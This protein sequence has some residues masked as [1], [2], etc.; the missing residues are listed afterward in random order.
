MRTPT[1]L[2]PALAALLAA[3]CSDSASSPPDAGPSDSDAALADAAALE[4]AGPEA[5]VVYFRDVKPILD[6]RCLPCHSEGHI[7]PMDLSV[8]RVAQAAAPLIQAAVAGRTMPP[9]H[10][11]NECRSYANDRS[12]ADQEIDTL[13]AWVEQGA[14]L[15]DPGV[16]GQPIPPRDQGLSRVDLRLPAPEAYTP[17]RNDDYRCLVLEWPEREVRFV[18]GFNLEPTNPAVVHHA[19]M[20]IATGPAVQTFRDRDAAAP[21]PGFPCFG[22][23]FDNGVELLGAW[24]PGSFGLEYP[25]GTGIQIDPGALIVIEMHYTMVAGQPAQPD[26]S[27]L[28]LRLEPQVERRA[29]IAPF[30]NFFDWPR[31]GMSIPANQADVVHRF[32]FDPNGFVQILAPWLRAT[33]IDIWAT[34]MHMHYLATSGSVHIRRGDDDRRECVIDIPRWDFHWQNG[35]LL[36]APIPFTIGVDRFL[37]ECHWDNTAAN[38]PIIDGRRRE[39]RDVNW[40]TASTD[41]MCIGYVYVTER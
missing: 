24:A 40:G 32:E 25:A 26:Q 19:N 20:Y 5:S 6:A 30:W 1:V 4:D 33:E 29:L 15:G 23:A 27:V 38:Q 17:Q 7:G 39:V 11:S 28:A 9:W 18:T 16:V 12:L 14:H 41:E 37:L 34:G 3:A 21:G 2:A 10:A 31:G 22:G 36:D 8:P 13:V 35:Y